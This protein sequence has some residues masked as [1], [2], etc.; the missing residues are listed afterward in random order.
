MKANDYIMCKVDSADIWL[1]LKIQILST[2]KSLEIGVE[3]KVDKELKG[4][5]LNEIIQKYC[6]EIWNNY[7]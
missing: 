2:Q 1:K 4:R 3:M 5:N 7:C 6:I